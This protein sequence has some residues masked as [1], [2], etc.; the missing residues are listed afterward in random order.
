MLKYAIYVR[1]SDDDKSVTEKSIR[2]QLEEVQAVVDREHLNIAKTFEES[3]SAKKP[4]NRPLYREMISMIE[5]GEIDAIV[6]YHINRLA[7]N[8]E[9]GGKLV[10]LLI[11]GTIKEIRTP[12]GVHKSGDNIIAIVVESAQA[13][14][15]S[16][17]LVK[18]VTR[19]MDGKL[20]RGGWNH[21]APQGYLNAR[22]PMNPDVGIIVKDPQRYDL[23]RKAWDMALT[24]AYTVAQITY[25]LDKVWGYR[26]R[27]TRK[28]GGGPLSDTAVSEILSNIFYAGFVR[29]KG[30]TYKG[31]HFDIAMV[32]PDEF[33]RVQEILGKSPT[34]SAK[35]HVYPYTGLMLCAYC[36]QQITAETKTVKSNGKRWVGY[37]CA[38]SY[39]RCT[40]RGMT[41]KF[42]EDEIITKLESI[43]IDEE[44]CDI[45]IDN[46]VRGLGSQVKPVEA[47]YA[48]QHQTLEDCEAE[49]DN[50][51]Q[52][53]IKGLEKDENRYKAQRAKIIDRRD[54]LTIEAAKAHAELERARANAIAAG[55]FIK[56]ARTEF[57]IALPERKR[58]IAHALG[59]TYTFYGREK[60]LEIEVHPILVEVVKFIKANEPALELQRRRFTTGSDKQK[61]GLLQPISSFGGP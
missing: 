15:Y 10:Q 42:V 50:L 51:A 12:Y 5:N 32:T 59:F 31:L 18:A 54:K 3:K 2:E 58:E 11:D 24:G 14:Q 9:E 39:N 13:T 53:W 55:N 35:K 4:N 20:K 7:R 19:G 41:H 1:K 49:L 26:R 8:M 30:Q 44:L 60:K 45:A 17:D 47:L 25:T 16:L 36:G 61:T 21:I 23:I 6:C 22:D 57:M 27:Q 56:F 48:Q 52:M 34:Q 29:S 37:H 38:D 43:T 33:A 46:I 28:T 40:Q